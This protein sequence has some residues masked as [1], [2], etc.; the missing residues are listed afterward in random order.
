MKNRWRAFL[1]IEAVLVLWL[2]YQITTHLF[3]LGM[4]MLGLFIFFSVQSSKKENKTPYY[5]I[6]LFLILFSLFSLTSFWV[7]LIVNGVWLL[8]EG[9]SHLKKMDNRLFKHAPWNKKDMIVVDTVEKMPKNGKKIKYEWLGNTKIGDQVYEWDDINL[10]VLA[11]DTIIDLGNTFLP[12][13]ENFVVLRK[14]FGK[15]RILVPTGTGILLEHHTLNGKVIFEGETISLS[16]ETL[17]IYSKD[18]DES[19]RKLKIITSVFLGDLEVIS[20]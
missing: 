15:T 11:G 6:S 14:G 1:F 10:S 20:V 18:Y 13:S 9:K 16:N 19:T 2:I 8:S 4:I 7:F 17:K 5:L 3:I 12:K